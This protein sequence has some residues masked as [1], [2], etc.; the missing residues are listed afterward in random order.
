[1]TEL[2]SPARRER[3]TVLAAL[4][5]FRATG[6]SRVFYTMLLF[7]YVCE[8]EGLT[9]SELAYVARM[10]VTTTAR[11][12]KA[13][14]GEPGADASD[15]DGEGE[16]LE[17]PLLEVRSSSEDHRL[18]FIHLSAAGRALRSRVGALIKSAAP[19]ED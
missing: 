7:L 13:M 16:G 18:K 11:L 2:A 12:V 10:H 5:L 3:N 9:V 19:I 6:A 15:S 17:A 14:A 4:E 8:N 1:M